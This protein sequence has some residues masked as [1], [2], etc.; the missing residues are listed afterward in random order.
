MEVDEKE[1]NLC[2]VSI[3]CQTFFRSLSICA[4]YKVWKVAI[5]VSTIETQKEIQ[6]GWVICQKSAIKGN[7]SVLFWVLMQSPSHHSMLTANL[8]VTT[9]KSVISKTTAVSFLNYIPH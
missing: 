9:Y 1:I 7:N 5:I 6:G 8:H 4:S 2:K 3:M